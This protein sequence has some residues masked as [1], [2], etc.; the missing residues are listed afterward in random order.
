[1]G[2]GYIRGDLDRMQNSRYRQARR[3]LLH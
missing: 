1:V 3:L 2:L